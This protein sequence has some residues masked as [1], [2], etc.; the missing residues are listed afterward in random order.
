[1]SEGDEAGASGLADAGSSSIPVGR[2]ARDRGQQA[3]DADQRDHP[4][5]VVGEDVERHFRSH[6]LQP[7]HLEVRGA[8]PGLDR[9]EGVLGRAASQGHRVGVAAKTLA[10]LVDQMLVLPS[11]DPAFLAG[12]AAV[13]QGAMLTVVDPVS[14]DL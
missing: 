10:Y 2:S 8:H 11:R 5:D 3:T 1:M 7:S 9:A 13:L 14:P 6:V 4:L 12:G